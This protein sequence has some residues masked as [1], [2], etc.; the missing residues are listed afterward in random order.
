MS[1]PT[2]NG[3]PAPQ[4]ASVDRL[5]DCNEPTL[6]GIPHGRPSI[7]GC[8]GCR[9]LCSR[10]PLRPVLT[11]RSASCTDPPTTF[12]KDTVCF[13][14]FG[15]S[16][17]SK[18]ACLERDGPQGLLTRCYLPL[19]FRVSLQFRRRASVRQTLHRLRWRREHPVRSC[20]SCHE[21]RCGSRWQRG[22]RAS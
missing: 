14:V 19:R 7:G 22:F 13:T 12:W 16:L 4:G 11:T 21:S 10:G 5:T 9:R 20:S 8:R 2:N 1:P 3:S 18:T 6:R 17:S 15:K